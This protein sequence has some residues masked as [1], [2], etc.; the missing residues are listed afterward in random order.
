MSST[1][2]L[3]SSAAMQLSIDAAA[4]QL[5]ASAVSLEPARRS[6]PFL[7]SSSFALP[8]ENDIK[9]PRVLT[10][11]DPPRCST[12]ALASVLTVGS[13]PLKPPIAPGYVAARSATSGPIAASGSTV[14]PTL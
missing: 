13:G 12:H 1:Q 7:L 9:R 6:T 14:T 5:C 11:H 3:P 8:P 2:S 10:D 4:P